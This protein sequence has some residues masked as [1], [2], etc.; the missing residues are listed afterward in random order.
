MPVIFGLMGYF[1]L[2]LA[3]RPVWDMATA[4]LSFLV[5]DEAPNFNADL[6]TVYDPDAADQ[7]PVTVYYGDGRTEAVTEDGAEA[8]AENT[9][10]A[11]TEA[12]EPDTESISE[13]G[14]SPAQQGT[15]KASETEPA[16]DEEPYIMITDIEF[17]LTGQQY[18]QIS[19]SRIG[20]DAPVY[21]YDTDEI[22]DY[23][24][25]QSIFSF[26]PGFGRII[27]L[28]GHNTTYFRCLEN[29]AEGD[30]IRFGTNYCN[31]TY[32][33][34]R[35]EVLDEKDLEDVLVEKMGKE[36][37]ELVMYTCYPFY[38]ITGRKTQRLTVFADRVEGYNVKWRNMDE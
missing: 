10:E 2:W 5:S 8:A 7:N 6:Q 29:I 18:A 16:K 1:L 30:E 9:A 24:V 34:S 11:G 21:W 38:A 25:G 12:A 13:A 37:E 33:V 22:L 26:L 31:Y 20:L 32:K 28:S 36:Q 35:V 4:A 19:C 17:P 15:A 14:G 3:L 27:I 23:G